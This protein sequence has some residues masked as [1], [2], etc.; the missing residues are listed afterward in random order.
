MGYAWRVPPLDP[1]RIEDYAVR[2]LPIRSGYRDE[3]TLDLHFTTSYSRIYEQIRKGQMGESVEDFLIV[4]P[5]K[6]IVSVN[7]YA[8]KINPRL[9]RMTSTPASTFV[10]PPPKASD[11][12]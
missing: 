7:L 5:V 12:G 10:S 3:K 8:L 11:A 9:L 4:L 6:N 2:L 1:R